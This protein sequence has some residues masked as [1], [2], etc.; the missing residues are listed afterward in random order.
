MKAYLK[1]Q[2]KG[3][4]GKMDGCVAYY[5][6]VREVFLVR[7]LPEFVPNIRT[8]KLHDIMVNLKQLNPSEAYKRDFKDY[9]F[10][11]NQLEENRFRRLISWSNLYLK[12][13]YAMQKAIPG[14]NLLILSRLQIET[15]DLPC[16][17][18]KSAIEAG[19]LPEV[20]GYARFTH[21]I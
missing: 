8:Q 11:Y 20:E 7:S 10:Q 17:T 21:A 16:R 14:V 12:M 1:N 13:L 15:E 6:P 2:F 9:L 4:S 3:Y 5:H 19:L 18:L